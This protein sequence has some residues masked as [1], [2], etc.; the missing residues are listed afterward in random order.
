[1]YNELLRGARQAS[2]KPAK[3]SLQDRSEI[4]IRE[5]SAKD[6]SCM[7]V[8]MKITQTTTWYDGKSIQHTTAALNAAAE[9]EQDKH[10]E[11]GVVNIYPQVRYQMIEGFGGAMTEASAY[12]LMQMDDDT[13]KQALEDLFGRKGNQLKFIRTSIDSSDFGLGQYQAVEDPVADPDLHTFN[14]DRDRKYIIPMIREAVKVSSQKINVLLSPWSPPAQWKERITVPKND[15]SLYTNDDAEAN[16]ISLRDHGGRLLPEYYESWARYFVK[17][18][19]GYLDEGIPVTM[20]TIQNESIAATSWDSC[21][22][23]PQ[24]QKTFI[25]DHLYPAMKKAGLS[26]K[27]GIFIWDHN[28]ERVFEWAE[29]ILDG[30]TA[31]MV[32]GVAFHWYSGDHFE[33]VQ[34]THEQFPDKVLMLSECCEALPDGD[35]FLHKAALHYAHDMIGNLN[36]GMNRW[37]DWNLILDKDGRPRYVECGCTAGLL[38]QNPSKYRTN[39][40]WYTIGHFSRYIQPGAVRIGVS[41]CDQSIEVTAAANP[42]GTIAVVLSNR[43]DEPREYC[44]RMCGQ[45]IRV[46]LPAGAISTLEITKTFRL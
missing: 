19:Q 20:V 12:A 8:L 22:W 39:M 38:V 44:L 30:E 34:M 35:A 26:D 2:L 23:T 45:L 18:V 14:L 4:R 7:E 11:L 46:E 28:K 6:Y 1:M 43:S 33:A 31:D 16:S 37:I 5:L 29:E 27:V 21:V 41:R 10:V 3:D 42:D 13:R 40:V 32:E 17:Y 15:P 25:R 36:S 9:A 24:E